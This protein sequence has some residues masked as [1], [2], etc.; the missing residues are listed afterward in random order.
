MSP[1]VRPTA[2]R[3]RMSVAPGTVDLMRIKMCS[4]HVDDPSAAFTFY[5]ETLGF[6]ELMRVPEH[7]LYIVRSPDEPDGTGLLLEP[8]DTKV[9]QAYQSGLH[10]L[11]IPTIVFGTP[12]VQA[13]YDR[14]RALG[15]RFQAAPSTDFS[16]TTAVF[17]DGCGNLIQLHQD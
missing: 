2:G 15:V 1:N 16:G 5:T 7:A 12:D 6:T 17:D 8:S 13:E 3:S 4:V 9:A 14:L 10:R 11:G